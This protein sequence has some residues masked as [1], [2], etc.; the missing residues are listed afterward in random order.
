MSQAPIHYVRIRTFCY[1]T[2]KLERVKEAFSFF[3][4]DDQEIKTEEIE[5][6]FG[7]TYWLLKSSI[8]KSQRIKKLTDFLKNNLNKDSYKKIKRQLSERIDEE[9]SFYLRFDKQKA[10][11]KELKLT[12]SGDSIVLRFKVAA[13][14]AKK[15]NAIEIMQKFF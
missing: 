7:N 9:C 12:S 15:Q 13:Y 8:E 11:N 3:L 5:G 10:Y 2:E 14:P 6:N 4:T 1:S